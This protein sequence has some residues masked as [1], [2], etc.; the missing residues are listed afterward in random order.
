MPPRAAPACR[1]RPG[2][3]AGSTGAHTR[4]CRSAAGPC[5]ASCTETRPARSRSHTGA[6][7]WCAHSGTPARRPRRTEGMRRYGTGR[8]THG[9]TR[10]AGHTAPRTSGPGRGT[11]CVPSPV[12]GHR[13]RC[14]SAPEPAGTARRPCAHGTAACSGGRRTRGAHRMARHTTTRT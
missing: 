7:A 13:G 2:R 12:C 14:G 10:A 8:R 1:A 4:A 3:R 5:R 11:T 6:C 9:H